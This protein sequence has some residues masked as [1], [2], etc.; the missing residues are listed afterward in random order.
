MISKMKGFVYGLPA[1]MACKSCSVHALAYIQERDCE[2]DDICSS[3]NTLF[4]FFVDFHNYVNERTGKQILSYDD[5]LKL[6]NST[7]SQ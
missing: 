4:K 7:L 1:I 5:V 3:K 2:L 6:Y